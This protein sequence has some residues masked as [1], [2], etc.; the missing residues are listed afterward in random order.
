MEKLKLLDGTEYTLAINGV[1]ELG[2]KVQIKVVT[3]DP[4]DRIYEKF[5]A[6]NA[7]TMTVIGETFTQKLTGYT[8][9]GSVVT[10]DTNAIIEMKYPVPSEEGN[11]PAEVEEVRGTVI[12]FE[13]CKER[14]ENKVEQNRADIDYLLMMEEQV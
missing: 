3:E 9:M 6:E 4:L 7:A 14:I 1:A 10:R 8:Q 12:T 11:T 5:T 13:M 2:E